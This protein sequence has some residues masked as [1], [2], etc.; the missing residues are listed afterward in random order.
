MW[1]V[2]KDFSFRNFILTFFQQF[3]IVLEDKI[4][5]ARG[6][7]FEFIL[8]GNVGVQRSG[9]GRPSGRCK[10]ITF[11]SRYLHIPNFEMLDA[12]VALAFN[13]IIEKSFIENSFFKMKV[14]NKKHKKRFFFRGKKIAHVIHDNLRSLA[15]MVSFSITLIC[16]QLLFEMMTFKNLIRHEKK[17]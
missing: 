10:I 4:K 1:L 8:G 7:L 3:H 13:K 2:N 17:C 12:R 15:F 5:N 11:N 16:S 9:D 6:C 14:G